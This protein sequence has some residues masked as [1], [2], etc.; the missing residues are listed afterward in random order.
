MEKTYLEFLFNTM[1]FYD[2]KSE[3]KVEKNQTK[4][5]LFFTNSAFCLRQIGIFRLFFFL[6]INGFNDKKSHAVLLF[7][8]DEN[9]S[10]L[11][12]TQI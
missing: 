9:I 8:F 2:I 6:F 12:N 5:K 4:W 10:R 11:Y 3:K 7:H 1:R